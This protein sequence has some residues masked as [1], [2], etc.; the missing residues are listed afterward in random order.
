MKPLL[1]WQITNKI[2]LDKSYYQTGSHNILHETRKAPQNSSVI[3]Q[4]TE[5]DD[6]HVLRLKHITLQYIN[7]YNLSLKK[8]VGQLLGVVKISRPGLQLCHHCKAAI[9]KKGGKLRPGN[10]YTPI[11]V[12]LHTHTYI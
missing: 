8:A 6:N 7:S 9:L 4:D 5:L 12:S 11:C 2:N 1:T 10:L 3:W